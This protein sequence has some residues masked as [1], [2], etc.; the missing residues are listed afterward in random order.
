M[1]TARLTYFAKRA[2]L[3]IGE[4][5]EY[6]Y[7]QYVHQVPGG[8][9]SNLRFQLKNLGLLD[10]LH[11]LVDDSLEAVDPA[12]FHSCQSRRPSWPE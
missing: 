6:D 7:S 10:R 1:Q 12:W 2:S 4:P 9:I 5:V 11:L 3:P 8:M